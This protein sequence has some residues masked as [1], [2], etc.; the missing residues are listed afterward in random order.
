MIKADQ[1]QDLDKQSIGYAAVFGLAEDLDMT[2]HQYSWSVSS[3][4]FGQL[5]ANYIFIYLMSRLPITKFV[6]ISVFVPQQPPLLK[7]LPL[8]ST[9]G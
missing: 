7:S 1:S 2:S 5:L 3:F 4:Y 6:G 8:I 9:T